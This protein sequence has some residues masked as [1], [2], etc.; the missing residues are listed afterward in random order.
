M[1][2]GRGLRQNKNMW[3]ESDI[4]ITKFAWAKT[5]NYIPLVWVSIDCESKIE[6]QDLE[7]EERWW[8]NSN[9]ATSYLIT[10]N[11]H[12]VVI[13]ANGLFAC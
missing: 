12:Y 9:S 5:Y 7:A 4:S 3:A 8:Q 2:V 10:R 11:K 1:C 13:N 6:K